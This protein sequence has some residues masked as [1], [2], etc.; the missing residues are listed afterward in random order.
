MPTRK[1]KLTR[2]YLTRNGPVDA[3]FRK[4]PVAK[5]RVAIA[6]D[7]LRWIKSSGVIIARGTYVGPTK[8][9]DSGE[10]GAVEPAGIQCI[11]NAKCE[12]CAKGGL[13]LATVM[14]TNT[15]SA[16]SV[17]DAHSNDIETKVCD[18]DRIFSSEQ[19]DLIE[20]VFE[21]GN[22]ING[23][24]SS[25]VSVSRELLTLWSERFPCKIA[26]SHLTP[27]LKRQVAIDSKLRFAAI[28][29]N[30]IQNK[31]TFVPENI[32]TVAKVKK[33]LARA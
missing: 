31:G 1:P 12:V 27:A 5:K 26:W 22:V 7:A 28:C 4:L 3:A 11:L 16:Y 23:G 17:L 25:G 10:L 9:W 13:F 18:K 32:P 33:Y 8:P 29:V 19:F 14:R 30:I 2:K 6:T 20:I 24:V 21:N 15:M